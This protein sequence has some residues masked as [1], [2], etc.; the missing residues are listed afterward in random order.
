MINKVGIPYHVGGDD[1]ITDMQRVFLDSINALFP[2]LLDNTNV[3]L[4]NLVVGI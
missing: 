4:L 3:L 1:A 2:N